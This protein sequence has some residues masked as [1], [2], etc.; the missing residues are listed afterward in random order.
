MKLTAMITNAVLRF[1]FLETLFDGNEIRYHSA[2]DNQ[3]N[4]KMINQ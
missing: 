2:R 1:L 3:I 4:S